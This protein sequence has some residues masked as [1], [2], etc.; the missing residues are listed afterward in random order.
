MEGTFNQ[1][2]CMFCSIKVSYT[3]YM[4]SVSQKNAVRKGWVIFSNPVFELY[5]QLLYIKINKDTSFM[6][7]LL[8][9][10]IWFS[11]VYLWT[12]FEIQKEKTP[13]ATTIPIL[14]NIDWL[15]YKSYIKEGCCSKTNFSYRTHSLLPN[16]FQTGQTSF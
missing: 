1:Y 13:P 16:H 4:Y 5:S 3:I 15:T 9:F 2:I 12:F 10:F 14:K 6:G 11:K 8:V 7:N